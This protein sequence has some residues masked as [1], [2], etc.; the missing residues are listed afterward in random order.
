MIAQRIIARVLFVAA[1]PV[2]FL[3][4][5]DPL[6]GGLALLFAASLLLVGFLLVAEPPRRYL[7]IPFA[8]SI[9]IGIA[10]I[11][12]VVIDMPQRPYEPLNPAVLVGIWIYRALVVLTFIGT[13]LN[14]IRFLRQPIK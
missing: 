10:V 8:L 12:I 11:A 6:E 2:V 14:A 9:L 1:I 3:G 5:I 7:W 13:L 4:L